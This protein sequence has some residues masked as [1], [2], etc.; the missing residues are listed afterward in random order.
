MKTERYGLDN[1][2]IIY[3]V[4]TWYFAHIISTLHNKNLSFHD[5]KTW[6]LYAMSCCLPANGQSN[7]QAL[8]AHKSLLPYTGHKYIWWMNQHFKLL[9]TMVGKKL[10]YYIKNY[11]FIICYFGTYCHLEPPHIWN[12]KFSFRS[13]C[14]LPPLLTALPFADSQVIGFSISFEPP[15]HRPVSLHPCL[16]P[17]AFLSCLDSVMV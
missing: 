9:G 8:T 1:N 2:N 5:S 12:N 6:V 7:F 15:V 10:V 11:Y 13:P 3:W 16:Y 17:L 14:P 4:L